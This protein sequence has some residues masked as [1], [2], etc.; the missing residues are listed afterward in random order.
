MSALSLIA[1]NDGETG[2]RIFKGL[3]L[4]LEAL[5]CEL[6]VT[7]SDAC[8]ALVLLEKTLATEPP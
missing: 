2:L 6:I 8:C 3:F 1:A 4:A 5:K 7:E